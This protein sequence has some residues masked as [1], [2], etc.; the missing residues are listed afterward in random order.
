MV[1][2]LKEKN[3]SLYKNESKLNTKKFGNNSIYQSSLLRDI[4]TDLPNESKN[5]LL[6]NDSIFLK[7]KSIETTT[8]KEI[9]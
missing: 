6:K 3:N 4:S 7:K 5:N 8:F 9:N 1:S 2:D